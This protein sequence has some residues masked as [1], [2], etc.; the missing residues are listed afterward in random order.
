MAARNVHSSCTSPGRR[1][2]SRHVGSQGGG[3]GGRLQVV[4]N[5]LD[6]LGMH[7]DS[8]LRVD[9]AQSRPQTVALH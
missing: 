9:S 6:A 2:E 5:V 7:L 1:S 3:E 8:S 4:A